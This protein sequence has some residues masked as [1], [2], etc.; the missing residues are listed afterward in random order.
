VTQTVDYQQAAATDDA[1]AAALQD[2]QVRESLAVIAANAPTLA[3]LVT[4]SQ[5]LL[6]RSRDIVDNI[7]GR[8]EILRSASDEREI[9][10]MQYR[11]LLLAFHDASPTVQSFL[12]SP[13]LQ[14]EIVDVISRVGEAALEADQATRGRTATVGGAFSLLRQ[15]KDPQVQETL[16]YFVTF[17]KAFGR[18]QQTNGQ[19]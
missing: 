8:V 19:G 4:A 7:N 3:L 10:F 15:L 2:P 16:A 12:Q 9:D 1:L 13:I 5:E 17:A 14:P 6:L 11:D 18:N